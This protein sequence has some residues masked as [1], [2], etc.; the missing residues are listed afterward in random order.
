MALYVPR[1]IPYENWQRYPDRRISGRSEARESILAVLGA[2]AL[3]SRHEY[4][5]HI[6]SIYSALALRLGVLPGGDGGRWNRT[7]C[8]ECVCDSKH[9]FFLQSF[10]L[11]LVLSHSYRGWIIHKWMI[12]GWFIAF[13]RIELWRFVNHG[14]PD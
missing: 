1:A 3:P 11:L 14:F 4:V 7:D 12:G 5:N 9:S 6:A 10:F 8:E 2:G 13:C